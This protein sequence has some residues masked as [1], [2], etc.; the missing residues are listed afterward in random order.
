[1]ENRKCLRC[2][3]ETRICGIKPDA[4]SYGLMITVDPGPAYG[5]HAHPLAAVCPVCGEVSVFIE[6]PETLFKEE[7]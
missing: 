3:A 6:D 2:G 7:D 1:M 5:K 4:A